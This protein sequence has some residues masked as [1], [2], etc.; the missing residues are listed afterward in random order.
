MQAIE[1]TD[2]IVIVMT[3]CPDAASAQ[4]I[5]GMVVTDKL[6][7]CVQRIPAMQSTYMWQGK[8][9]DE[10]EVLLLIKTLPHAVPALTRR[11]LEVHPYEVPELL[12]QTADCGNEAYLQWVRTNVFA[13]T[14]P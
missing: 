4:Q 12:I 3:T 14:S 2:E 8:L 5:A 11:I 9:Q 13:P 10:A 1:A 7:A 6:A